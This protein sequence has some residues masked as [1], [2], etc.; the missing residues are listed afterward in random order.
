M[1]FQRKRARM[2]ALVATTITYGQLYE[3]TVSY[4]IYTAACLCLCAVVWQLLYVFNEDTD[5][6]I[7]YNVG[8]YI[9]E[10]LFLVF[11]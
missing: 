11:A 10:F 4:S 6:F 3:H 2:M 5:V 1:F 8:T 9:C 7:R